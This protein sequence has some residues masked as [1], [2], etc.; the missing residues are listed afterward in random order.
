MGR[1][2]LASCLLLSIACGTSLKQAQ[3]SVQRYEQC[4]GAD[5]NPSVTLDQR[6]QCWSD[7]LDARVEDDPPERVR[8]AEM[9]LAQLSVDPST[10][11][12]PNPAPQPPPTY[13]HK[14]PRSPPAVYPSSA[15]LPLCNDHWADCNA[16]CLMRDKACLTACQSEYRI[17]TGGCP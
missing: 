6:L 9:R 15:C 8:Y 5:F 12:I 17:C 2:F 11:P 7:W 14:Y 13:E 10:R 4:Y 1:V 16:H 3:T